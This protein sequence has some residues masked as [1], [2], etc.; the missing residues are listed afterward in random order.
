MKRKIFA[1][2]LIALPLFATAQDSLFY[3]T[4]QNSFYLFTQIVDPEDDQVFTSTQIRIGDTTE[5]AQFAINLAN[6]PALQY[7]DGIR[8]VAARAEVNQARSA[9]NTLLQD[10][11]GQNVNQV[12]RGLYADRYTGIWR[13]TRDTADFFIEMA[14]NMTWEE[15]N[16]SQGQATPASGGRSG[17]FI[18]LA[19]ECF[20]VT[21]VAPDPEDVAP[22]RT[23]NNRD[24]YYDAARELR[25]VYLGNL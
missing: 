1:V 6:D 25:L 4:L 19:A 22:W 24:I 13:V 11:I 9:S 17:N 8:K 5:A 18:I 12:F 2:L 10:I 3:D 23:I 16:I 20:R 7:K 21:G 15:V 14:V